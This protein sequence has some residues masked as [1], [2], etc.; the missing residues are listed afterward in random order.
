MRNLEEKIELQKK[1]YRKLFVTDITFLAAHPPFY[2]FAPE[3]SGVAG[4][5]L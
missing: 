2:I 1:V 5:P 4:T 3:N